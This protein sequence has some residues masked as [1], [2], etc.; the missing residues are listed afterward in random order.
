[1]YVALETSQSWVV[2]KY[3]LVYTILYQYQSPSS[4]MHWRP[5]IRRS[6][7]WTDVYSQN[8]YFFQGKRNGTDSREVYEREQGC[9]RSEEP[10]CGGAP[11]DE[12]AR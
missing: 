11:T 7:S 8:V 3:P 9:G 5:F 4:S 2:S 1:M 10:S 12:V 6:S